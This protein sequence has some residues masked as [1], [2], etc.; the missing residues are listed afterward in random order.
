M[1]KKIRTREFWFQVLKQ[2]ICI[3]MVIIVV[4]PILLT[5]FA[6]LKN[7]G[8]MVTTSPL[9]LPSFD[10]ITLENYA[11]VFQN[12]YLLIGF[13]N[14]LIILVVSIFFN[15][16]LGTVTAYI[17]ERFKFRFKNAVVSLFFIGMLVPTFVTEIARFKI[18]NGLGL[19]NTL[20]A[21]IVIYVASDLMQCTST[22]N[23]SQRFRRHW[24]KVHCWMDAATSV[25][26]PALSSRCWPRLRQRWSL[27]RPSPSSTICTF[28]TCIC[29]RISCAP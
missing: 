20:G 10:R 1:L 5:L 18:I 27:S 11:K 13:K 6:S 8:D 9:A 19:Y 22:G 14:T 16:I 12:K 3:T 24:M 4:L 7:K 15:V 17:I 25:F 28:P 26:L 2:L 21:P 29:P 23:S